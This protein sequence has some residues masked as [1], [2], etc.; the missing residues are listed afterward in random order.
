MSGDEYAGH[1]EKWAGIILTAFQG[2]EQ[3]PT[4]QPQTRL[5]DASHHHRHQPGTHRIAPAS[6]LHARYTHL[7]DQGPVRAL[8]DCHTHHGQPCSEQIQREFEPLVYGR[9]LTSLFLGEWN[10]RD[11]LLFERMLHTG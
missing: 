10:H 11:V 3:K 6:P 1:A 5:S 4:A 2:S 9:S 8:K 7:P